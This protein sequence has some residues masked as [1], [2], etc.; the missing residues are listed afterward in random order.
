MNK[1]SPETD[2][3]S[4]DISFNGSTILVVDDEEE[5]VE[6]ARR[7]LQRVGFHVDSANGGQAA[8]EKLSNNQYDLLLLDLIMPK[9]DG[10]EVLTR[11]ADFKA[12]IPVLVC[13]GIRDP[14]DVARVFRLGAADFL[15]KPLNW[16]NVLNVIQRIQETKQAKAALD[17]LVSS[18]VGLTGQEFFHNAVRGL[19]SWLNADAAYIGLII[20][21]GQIQPLSMYLDGQ[22]MSDYR[23]RLKDTPCGLTINDG[24]CFYEKNISKLFPDCKDLQTLGAEGYAAVPIMEDVDDAI[25]ILWVISR[26]HFHP[27]KQWKDVLN[28]IAAKASSE[29]QRLQVLNDYKE[30]TRRYRDLTET[31]QDFVWEVNRDGIY[32]YC[33]PQ[34]IEMLGYT[35]EEL[36]GKSPF[37]LMPPQEAKRIGAEFQKIVTEKT[38]FKF[39]ENKNFKK[40]D[41]RSF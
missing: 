30:S 19:C 29:I 16:E 13:S 18:M 2:K 20:D 41:K 32:T 38:S 9:I 26:K 40:M 10:F 11:I 14:N 27:P 22:H 33:S 15:D 34:C 31:T 1:L 28:I 24:I 4:T 23:Y 8:L 5:L 12:S 21:D 17:T 35:P 25:G 6:I 37:D 3:N 7:K 36:H 39:L